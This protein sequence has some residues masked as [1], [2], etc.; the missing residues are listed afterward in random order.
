MD[1]SSKEWEAFQESAIWLDMRATFLERIQLYQQDLAVLDNTRE[2]DIELK[3]RVAELRYILEFP[4][5][6]INV[7]KEEEN[8]GAESGS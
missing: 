6:S 4:A 7:A 5:I 1:L 3:A 2:K 8:G